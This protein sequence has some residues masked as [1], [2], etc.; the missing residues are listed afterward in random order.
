MPGATRG[1]QPQHGARERRRELPGEPGGQR[2]G[3]RRGEQPVEDVE[4]VRAD[5]GEQHQRLDPVGCGGSDLLRDAAAVGVADEDGAVDAVTVEDVKH[6]GGVDFEA[7]ARLLARPVTWPVDGDRMERFRQGGDHRL[8]VG[9]QPWL[10][11]QQHEVTGVHS[12][13]VSRATGTPAS[14]M[15]SLPDAGRL[16]I[17]A[18]RFAAGRSEDVLVLGDGDR[19][20]ERPHQVPAR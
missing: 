3:D 19:E 2:A 20:A 5:G 10:A 17:Y 6:R 4:A 7:A 8:P 14:A 15:T 12:S 1:Q 16:A 18:V 11:V 9:P 13:S